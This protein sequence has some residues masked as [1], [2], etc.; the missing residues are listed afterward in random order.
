MDKR[1]KE[2]NDRKLEIRSML[3]GEEKVDLDALEKELADII[4]PSEDP[5]DSTVAKPFSQGVEYVRFM[6]PENAALNVFTR[7]EMTAKIESGTLMSRFILIKD[8]DE[9]YDLCSS[10]FEEVWKFRH[11]VLLQTR[12]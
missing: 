7:E 11:M 5:W 2:I 12:P 1:L 9:I 4:P 3:Q 6:L 8:D 10:R